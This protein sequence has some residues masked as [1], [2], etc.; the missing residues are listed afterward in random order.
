MKKAFDSVYRNGLWYELFHSGV[1]G[2]MLR[3]IRYTYSKVM[4][5]V[6]GDNLLSECFDSKV[7]LKQ[8]GVI[9]PL[10]YALFVDDL[11][12]YLKEKHAD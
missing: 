10:L 5:F 9:S 8:G 2:K 7:G 11:E 3:I 6:K 12:L 1:N 4:A